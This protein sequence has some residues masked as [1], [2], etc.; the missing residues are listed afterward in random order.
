MC[1]PQMEVEF[2]S[3][4]R[5][6]WAAFNIYLWISI[7]SI[8]LLLQ[9]NTSTQVV[10]GPSLVKPTESV[11]AQTTLVALSHDALNPSK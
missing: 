5:E 8:Y 1:T 7:F 9:I 2:L 3:L 10:K 4:F 11:F 6:H